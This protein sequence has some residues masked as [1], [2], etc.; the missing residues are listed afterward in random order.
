[1]MVVD[2]WVKAHRA[3][4]ER[5]GEDYSF[6]DDGDNK[7]IR[8]QIGRMIPKI[9]ARK[10]TMEDWFSWLEHNQWAQTKGYNPM[11][12][13]TDAMLVNFSIWKKDDL[14]IISEPEKVEPKKETIE[15][16]KKK[17]RFFNE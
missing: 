12:V 15:E 10:K 17:W 2:R 16:Y 5:Q 14:P 9:L 7:R 3:M 8:G 13:Y 4:A 11:L 1:M 6:L